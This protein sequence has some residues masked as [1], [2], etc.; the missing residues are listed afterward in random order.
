MTDKKFVC[1]DA[2]VLCSPLLNVYEKLVFLML[3]ALADNENTCTASAGYIARQCNI[4]SCQVHRCIRKLE[5][6]GLVEIVA[7]KGVDGGTLPNTYML[8]K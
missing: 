2:N 7:R 4:S 1:V 8:R 3:H 5:D 6:E